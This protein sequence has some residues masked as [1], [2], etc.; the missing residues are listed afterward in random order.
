MGSNAS[1]NTNFLTVANTNV[2][3]V[4]LDDVDESG[5]SVMKHIL[6]D[7]VLAMRAWT[8]RLG[9]GFLQT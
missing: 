9:V 4:R 6:R 8:C 2:L 1:Q 7:R 5:E 3:V